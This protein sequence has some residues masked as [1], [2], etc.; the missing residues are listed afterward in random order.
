MHDPLAMSMQWVHKSIKHIIFYK[1][2]A[3]R[4]R[5]ESLR[6]SLFQLSPAL[7]MINTNI[8]S[9]QLVE[10]N[11]KLDTTAAQNQS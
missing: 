1:I 7:K 4:E 10:L 5:K 2:Q 9:Q 3:R 6:H 11:P 8:L